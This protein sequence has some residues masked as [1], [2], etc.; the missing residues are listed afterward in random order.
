MMTRLYRTEK[1]ASPEEKYEELRSILRH[2]EEIK[3]PYAGR[4]A[5]RGLRPEHING[6]E[7]LSLLPTTTK[8]DLL[9]CYPLGW[10]ARDKKDIVRIH[11]TSGTT[12]KPTLVAYTAEDV[13][14]WA[15]NMAWCIGLSGVNENDV[16]Q[17]SF[18][19]GLFTGGLGYHDGADLLGAV[20]V[21]VSGGFT[22]RQIALMKDLGT[23]VLACAPSYALRIAEGLDEK[24]RDGIA[25]RL[26]LFG[27]E[28]WSEELRGFLESRLGIK[29]IDIYGLSEAMGPGVSAECLEQNGLHISDDF[30]AQIVDPKTLAPAPDGDEG[31]LVLTSWRKSAFPVIRYRT[32]DLTSLMSGACP[33]G[34]P[35][36]RMAR[37]R[38]R[39][40]DML[41]FHGVNVF[42]SQVESAVC[43]V[44]G[45][46]PNY[47]INAWKERGLQNISL[48]CERSPESSG[49]DLPRME[50]ELSKAIK[51]SIGVTIPFEILA[52]GIMPRGDNK[53]VRIRKK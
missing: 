17:I 29:A 20:V 8:Y 49:D 24:G 19:Y 3:H 33:C 50:H 42:P 18:S 21:P 45:L 36:P 40:D 6:Y 48:E 28:A 7:D 39:S 53:A 2:L 52:P 38:G 1:L 41:I 23:T 22:D 37:V 4:M 26:G 51:Q 34:E 47:R 14:M 10:L 31:E 16:V 32:R 25:L 46:T 13:A 15:R 43:G 5:E 9:N 30:I 11:A 35:T 44:P 12:G 27:A